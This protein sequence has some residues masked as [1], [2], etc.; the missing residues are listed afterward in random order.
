MGRLTISLTVGAMLIIY[1]A[2]TGCAA[3]GDALD[4][5]SW[6]LTSLNG[7]SPIAGST[8]TLAFEDG[9]ASGS[10]GCNS[11]GGSYTLSGA[12]GVTF[13]DVFST[14]MACV[15]PEGVMEQEIQYLDILGAAHGYSMQDN[16][17]QIFTPDG[18][19]LQFVSQGQ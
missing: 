1:G 8:I 3:T 2:L 13:R 10:A 7:S 17:L 11:Y 18:A 19:F 14:M 9:R 16:T 15:G 6:V 12:D 4:G 5:T